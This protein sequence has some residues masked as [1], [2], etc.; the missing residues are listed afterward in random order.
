M[1]LARIGASGRLQAIDRPAEKSQQAV[2]LYTGWLGRLFVDPL[3]FSRSTGIL[4]RNLVLFNDPDRTAYHGKKNEVEP[5]IATIIEWQKNYLSERDYI[6]EL[7]CCGTSSGAYASILFGHHLKADAVYA[8]G[9]FTRLD[10]ESFLHEASPYRKLTHNIDLGLFPDDHVDLK[11]LLT[12]SNNKTKYHLYFSEDF[13]EDV[14][15]AERV[16]ACSGVVLHPVPGR[17]H[18]IFDSPEGRA[19]VET[20]F[21]PLR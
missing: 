21:P 2:F 10:L 8:F 18:N 15:Q 13:A 17:T 5:D 14:E 1:G 7:Y 20:I 9:A 4:D 19:L 11:L 6:K 16:A 12:K 3:T